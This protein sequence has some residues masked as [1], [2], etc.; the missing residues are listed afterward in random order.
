MGKYEGILSQYEAHDGIKSE[1]FT[2]RAY[3]DLNHL[4]QIK[5]LLLMLKNQR[6]EAMR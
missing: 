2:I 4:I 3:D 1:D 6:L 5:E